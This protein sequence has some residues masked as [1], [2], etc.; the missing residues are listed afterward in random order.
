M[1]VLIYTQVIRTPAPSW[2]ARSD[3]AWRVRVSQS[4]P[5]WDNASHRQ[6]ALCRGTMGRATHPDGGQRVFQHP[7][8]ATGP[9]GGARWGEEGGFP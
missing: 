7:Y 2:R 8:L 4:A 6:A 5:C 1:K 3:P 9:T